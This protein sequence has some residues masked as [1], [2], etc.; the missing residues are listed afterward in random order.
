[1]LELCLEEAEPW[2]GGFLFGHI[3]FPAA[4]PAGGGIER[5]LG[6]TRSHN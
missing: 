6:P 3:S 4:R 5:I 2:I 1:L